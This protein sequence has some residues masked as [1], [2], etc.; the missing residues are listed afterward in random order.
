MA[1][2]K[3]LWYYTAKSLAADVLRGRIT[4]RTESGAFVCA[5]V[6][7]VL[8]RTEKR[9]NG[10]LRVAVVDETVRKNMKYVAG[11]AMQLHMCERTVVQYTSDFVYDVARELGFW[12]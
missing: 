9:D 11:V 10:K 7:T 2:T 5:C 3:K 4:D 12:E 6:K 8:G 1:K